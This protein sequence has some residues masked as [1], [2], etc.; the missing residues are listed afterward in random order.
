VWNLTRRCKGLVVAL[1]LLA[2]AC[3]VADD[4]PQWRGPNRNGISAETNWL[5]NWPPKEEWRTPLGRGYASVAVVGDRLY[6]MGWNATTTN[7]VV[8]C[9]DALTGTQ[10]WSHAYHCSYGAS[11]IEDFKGPRCTPAVDGTNVY[12]YSGEG[13]LHCFDA[14]SGTV[15]W[16]EVHD[17]ALPW[18]GQGC[19]P[20]I[21]GD[22]VLLNAGESG[23]AVNKHDGTEVWNS[24]GVKGA[25][26]YSSAFAMTWNGQRTVVLFSRSGVDGVALGTGQE[27][28]S[29]PLRSFFNI[30]DP[31]VYGNKI[32]VSN[33]DPEHSASELLELT[34]EGI[35]EASYD[36]QM[37]CNWAT[38]VLLGDHLYG[39]DDNTLT[40]IDMRDGSVCWAEEDAPL[41]EG[42]LMAALM[43]AGN[44]L[45]VQGFMG[46]LVVLK[47]TPVSYDTEGR[48][49][50]TIDSGLVG[51]SW[52]APPALA[53][54]R[55]Y[56]RSELGMLVCLRTGPPAADIDQNGMADNWER[57]HFATHS[58]GIGPEDDLD[59]DGLDNRTEY[60][61]GTVPTNGTSRYGLGIAASNGNV[62]VRYETLPA[63]GPGYE[64]WSRYYRLEEGTKLLT[65]G[66]GAVGGH[67][68]V[69]GDGVTRAHTNRM[70]GPAGAY[71]MGVRLESDSGD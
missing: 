71:R 36:I 50:V 59:L 56:C 15:I 65:P 67:T 6:T 35:G 39:Y 31:V 22:L 19:S 12:T 58:V 27:L 28:W 55:I 42:G 45:I 5:I 53:N 46:P 20:Y 24:G 41:A 30:I 68:D 62:I 40:C 38:P 43:A 64:G 47:A 29:Y 32:F 16:D 69:P 18:W 57:E 25:A 9:L 4:W 14:A 34:A 8:Y 21:E 66:W 13:H 2:A 44:K 33:A 23:V 51:D 26:G 10:L 37:G 70:P 61:V 48:A 3:V 7:D 52:Y 60:I 63:I 11:Y 49:V 17:T 54:G 1:L